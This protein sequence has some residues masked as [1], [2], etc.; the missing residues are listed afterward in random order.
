MIV[1]DHI[2]ISNVEDHNVAEAGG[3]SPPLAPPSTTVH[4]ASSSKKIIAIIGLTKENIMKEIDDVE[5][6]GYYIR[7][8]ATSMHYW[9][10]GLTHTKRKGPLIVLTKQEEEELVIWCKE[11]DY[12]SHG[13]ELL[14]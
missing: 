11:M 5:F 12:M 13:V 10:I 6:H 14:Q 9:L 2:S 7:V 1:V 8:V 3:V 4:G